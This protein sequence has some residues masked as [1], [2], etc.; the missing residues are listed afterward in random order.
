MRDT[1]RHDWRLPPVSGKRPKVLLTVHS[2]GGPLARFIVQRA[3]RSLLTLWIVLTAVFFVLRISGDP[4]TTMLGPDASEAAL[5]AFRARHGL[6]DPLIT[7]Y[8]LYFTNII[9]G[10]FGDSMQYGRPVSELFMQRLPAT[11]ELAAWAMLIAFVVGIPAGVVGA[12]KRNTVWDRLTMFGAFVGQSAPNFFVG[13]LLI[14]V[15][16]MQLNWLPSSGRGEPDQIVMPALT[17]ATGLLASL[18]RMTRSS[19]LEVVN[20]DYIKTARAKG[21]R[22]S[23]ILRDHTLRNAALPIVTL[24][25]IWISGIIGGAAVTETVFAWPGIGRLIV[26]AVSSRDYPVVQTIVLVIAA[27]VVTVNLI[28]DIVYGWLDPRISI[29]SD[30]GSSA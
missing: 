7:Q 15:L 1:I 23:R 24:L 9:R 30:G 22:E 21:L 28:V 17:L 2:L 14:L 25:G 10:E 16:S 13:I 19:V 5:D 4:A 29:S 3:I 8:G 20:A 6:D 11:L 18:A 12:I 27:T 26:E